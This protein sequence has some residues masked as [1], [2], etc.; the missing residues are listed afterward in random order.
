VAFGY[1]D[2]E[3][4]D[5]RSVRL[6]R[7]PNQRSEIVLSQ[8]W[9]AGPLRP[10]ETAE[11]NL[12]LVQSWRG[13][14]TVILNDRTIFQDQLINDGFVKAS[15]ARVGLGAYAHE[16]NLFS[17]RYRNLQ[18]RR[19]TTPPQLSRQPEIVTASNKK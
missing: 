4:Y 15:N 3:T 14:L 5:W 2:F 13:K 17:V 16:G 1:P 19:L 12:F 10:V 18:L 8:H 6:R 9:K 11:R 7:Q